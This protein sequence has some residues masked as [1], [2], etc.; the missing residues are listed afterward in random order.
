[1]R[2]ETIRTRG[3]AASDHGNHYRSQPAAITALGNA[4]RA[5]IAGA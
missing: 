5:L 1:L 3:R 4:I 2:A